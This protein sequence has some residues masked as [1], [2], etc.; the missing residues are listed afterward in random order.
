MK[1]VGGDKH[2]LTVRASDVNGVED[3]EALEVIVNNVGDGRSSCYLRYERKA[4]TVSLMNDAGTAFSE[5]IQS[6]S[7]KRLSN[8]YCTIGAPEAPV[9]K[10]AYVVS[11]TIELSLT[12]KLRNRRII[13]LSAVDL[14]GLRQSWRDYAV[15]PEAP[16]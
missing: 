1:H 16:H 12:E 10:S 6:G 9:V 5:P 15:L 2:V 8:S 4:I 14:G 7:A 13:F 11:F 3:V